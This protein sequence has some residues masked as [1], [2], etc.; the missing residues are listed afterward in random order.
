MAIFKCK[1]CGGD[2]EVSEEIKIIECDY[3]GTNQTV[4]TADNEKKINLFNRANRLRM[5]NEFD[6]ASGIYE[7]IIV[8]F[9][10]EAEAYWGLCLCKYGIEYVDDPATA[11]K[12]PTCHRSSFESIM[13]DSDFEQVME[14]A[15]S[16]ARKVYR[17]E[18]KVIEEIRKGIIEVSA[19]EKPYDIFI[20]YKETAENGDRTLDSVIAQDVYNELTDRGYRVFFSRITLENKLGVEYEPYIFA[21]LNSAKIMLVFGTDYEYFNAVWVKNEWSRYLKLMANDKTKHLIPCYK[22]VDAYDIPK[23]FA[24]L[25]AQDMGKVGAIQDLLRGIE[26]IIPKENKSAAE[27]AIKQ[28]S[29]ANPSAE[30]YLKRAF[31]FLEDGNFRSADEYCEKV[32]D[33]DPENA[34]GY[35]GKLLAEL[36][37][38]KQEDLKD[39]SES[40]EEKNNYLKVKRY[41][42]TSLV[43]TL[44]SYIAL[45]KNRIEQTRIKAENL[46]SLIPSMQKLQNLIC[47]GRKQT[48]G[49]VT[50]GTVVAVGNN[51]Y[52]E[53]NV[54]EWSDTIAVSSGFRHHTVSL[55]ADG[56]VVAVGNNENGEC[57]VGGWKDI[58]AISAGDQHTVGLKKDGTVVAVGNNNFRQCN[59]K[60]WKDIVAISAGGF[61][62]VGL[63]K[64]GTVV[65]VGRCSDDQCNVREWKD[66]VAISAGGWHT[67]GLKSDGTVVVAGNNDKAKCNVRDWSDIIAVSAG[68]WHTAGLKKDGTVVAV[69]DNDDGQCDIDGW[70]LFSSVDTIDQ[71]REKAKKEK[72]I[73]ISSEDKKRL[74]PVQKMIPIAMNLIAAGADH[75]AC[76]KTDGTVVATE[77]KNKPHY[78]SG[79]CDVSGWKDVVAVSA[80]SWH[81]AALK[82]DGTVV[83]TEYKGEPQQYNGQ[84]D[85]GSWKDIVAVS[86][87]ICHTV[88][89]KSDGTVIATEYIAPPDNEDDYY[90]GQCD[91][92]S[93]KDII[94]IAA[95]NVH[96]VGLKSDGTALWVGYDN[97][98]LERWTVDDW[99]DVV[100]VSTGSYHTVGL[101]SDGT[102]VAV[103]LNEYGEC[104]VDNWKNMMLP[105][106]KPM[107]V[108]PKNPK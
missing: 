78:Y 72:A 37:V 40:F 27:T 10:E 80:G 52:G 24:K 55:K 41:G 5:S 93:W 82:F 21:A 81:T 46:R 11:K 59:V 29:S 92:S 39:L 96:T 38:R 61:H 31:I 45:I 20:C 74:S 107:T 47:A 12:I 101:K 75:T 89:L 50:D 70:R 30:S 91:V 108:Q 65:A 8:D 102:V 66:I 3:C 57:N 68:S 64:D 105:N 90:I 7:S 76:V 13:D 19:N 15:D 14:N 22:G 63:K 62:T 98:Y 77:Y 84:C 1:M 49:F 36:R 100:S 103:G 58:V 44:E 87:G 104:G 4:P 23:E 35:L 16:V 26:K 17:E 73:Q 25:Q 42:D 53:C 9:P 79:Q 48:V 85:V 43:A 71:E 86:A 94:A 28:Q 69:G 32:L 95:R 2:L 33:I 97:L 83:A 60:D 34:Q 54:R 88:G 106:Q 67:V 18:A 51:G 99:S 56:T 6:K